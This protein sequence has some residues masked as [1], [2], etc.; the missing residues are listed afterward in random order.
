MKIRTDDPLY[1][2]HVDRFWG[3]LLPRMAPLLYSNGG[4]IV[5]VQV[6]LSVESA[7]HR[8]PPGMPCM[9]FRG[10]KG[11]WEAVHVGPLCSKI[12]VDVCMPAA[13]SMQAGG[14][15]LS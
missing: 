13:S 9:H 6:C 7:I 11:A 14:C 8:F 15:R 1:L 10:S 2:N 12:A 5:M 3:Q 4:P